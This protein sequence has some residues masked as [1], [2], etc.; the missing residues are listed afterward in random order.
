METKLVYLTDPSTEK[1]AIVLDVQPSTDIPG[2]YVIILDQTI[3][4]PQGGGQPA[5]NGFIESADKSAHFVVDDVRKKEGV[6]YHTGTVT[7][8]QFI[9]GMPVMLHVDVARRK[10]HNRLH[11]AAHIIDIALAQCDIAWKPSKGYHFPDGAY[12]EYEG[13]IDG[14]VADV[15]LPKLQEKVKH[16][17]GEHLPVN[18]MYL[19][20]EKQ[21]AWDLEIPP[22]L[23]PNDA[24]RVMQV[25]AFKPIVCG[26]THVGN[27]EELGTVTVGAIKNKK[28]VVRVSYGVM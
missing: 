27:T 26:G 4:Y 25:D 6:V 19:T 14:A 13:T 1:A 11:S 5:D 12:V 8:G 16:L 23:S 7:R 10:F 22:F 2:K 18:I 3:F 21:Q 9:P 28:G 20:P 24:V 17:I 15:L